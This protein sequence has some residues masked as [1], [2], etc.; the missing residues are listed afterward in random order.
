MAKAGSKKPR[1][2]KEPTY[3]RFRYSKR[4]KHAQKLS[5]APKLFMQSL[6]L[7][8]KNW[9]FFAGL[10]LVYGVLALIFVKGIAGTGNI[11]DIKTALDESFTGT[12]NQISNSVTLF[13]VLVSSSA[14]ADQTA[15]LYQSIFVVIASLATI[16]GLRRVQD[17][18][19]G[20]PLRI[21]QAYY[22]G[23][24]PLIPFLLVCGLILLQLIPFMLGATA[25]SVILGT[26]LAVG[27]LEQTIWATVFMVLA[28]WSLYMITPSVI[29]LL[30]VTLPDMTPMRAIRSAR[31]LVLYRRWTVLRKLLFM[32]FILLVIS[33]VVMLPFILW[34]PV[35]ASW[36]FFVWGLMLVPVTW[37]YVYA[38]Y[39]ELL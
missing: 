39:R 26:G 12:A 11:T 10:T 4:I 13:G 34:I 35:A 19:D 17:N 28:I 32:P 16:W 9:K 29:A 33:F 30:I 6:R 1:R 27:M 8:A 22:K 18:Q 20:K 25:Y 38:L 23:M 21:K 5:S 36:A 14:A 24:Q 3:K 15:N 2:L 31:K 37:S 7:L